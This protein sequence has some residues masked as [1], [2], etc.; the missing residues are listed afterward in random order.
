VNL[1]RIA[2]IQTLHQVGS[3]LGTAAR[4]MHHE[5]FSLYIKSFLCMRGVDLY[6]R[7]ALSIALQKYLPFFY[8]LPHSN[9]VNNLFVEYMGVSC[10]LL[11][12]HSTWKFWYQTCEKQEGG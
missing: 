1:H 8:L 9:T 12:K 4:H 11:L 6:N 3:L 7:A 5:A 10:V 2:A